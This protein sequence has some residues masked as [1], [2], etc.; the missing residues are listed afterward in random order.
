MHIYLS[1]NNF[2][3]E[4]FTVTKKISIDK[5]S[6]VMNFSNIQPTI[7]KCQISTNHSTEFKFLI[8]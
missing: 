2:Y 5:T 8:V 4:Q 1:K 7:R 3:L 6:V